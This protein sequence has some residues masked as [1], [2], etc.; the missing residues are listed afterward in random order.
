MSYPFKRGQLV[1]A[2]RTQQNGLP[3]PQMDLTA[4]QDGITSTAAV[5]TLVDLKTDPPVRYQVSCFNIFQIHR[6]LEQ[7]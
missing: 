7:Q 4:A 2:Y 5:I 6:G 3:H 1:T